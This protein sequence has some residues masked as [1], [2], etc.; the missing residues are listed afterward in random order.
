MDVT[1]ANSAFVSAP[2]R[3]LLRGGRWRPL[4]LRV[5]YG[6]LRH[7]SQGVFLIDTGIGLQAL[8]AAGRGRML[9]AY[10]AALRY[11][12]VADAAPVAVLAR[13]GVQPSAVAGVIVTHFHADH[14]A[15][16]HDFPQARIIADGPA[17]AHVL[18]QS[19]LANQ[20]HGIFPALLPVDIL[21]RLVDIR[22]LPLHPLPEDLGQGH[23]IFGD[24]TC[25]TVDLPGHAKGHFGLVFPQLRHPMLYGCDVQWLSAALLPGQAPGYPARFIL[26]DAAA[27]ATST[28]RLQRWQTAG[29]AVVL[30][31]DPDLTPW[32]I[33]AA[34]P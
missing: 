28:A 34:L 33:E 2:E 13:L 32:D 5:R 1:F 16:L 3:F 30:C 22:T 4:S 21:Q 20:R 26:D 9:R 18:A 11:R 23:D 7:P 8:S 14:V 15:C 17:L 27:N 19:A 10:G 24:G 12:L 29:G 6:V 25:V 31:H